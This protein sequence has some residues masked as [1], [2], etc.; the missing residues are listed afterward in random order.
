MTALLALPSRRNVCQ[1]L[2]DWDDLTV[3]LQDDVT[4]DRSEDDP[5]MEWATWMMETEMSWS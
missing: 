2:L 5:K 1:P 3:P 4:T